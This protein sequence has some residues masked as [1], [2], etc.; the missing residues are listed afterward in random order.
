MNRCE[1]ELTMTSRR[2][3]GGGGAVAEFVDLVVYK[4][5]LFDIDVFSGMPLADSSR[6]RK[7][8]FTALWEELNSGARREVLLCVH[9]VL[10]YPLDD[11]RHRKGFA[12][13]VI[14]LSV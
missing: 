3:K 1:T 11:I 4:C 10:L 13:P 6:N 12:E 2:S 5:V 9:R 14:P 7:Q 8:I